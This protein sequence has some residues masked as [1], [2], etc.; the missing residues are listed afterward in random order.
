MSLSEQGD[1]WK[2]FIGLQLLI[3]D[4][5]RIRKQLTFDTDADGVTVQ[6][7]L[8]DVTADLSNYYGK[9][10]RQGQ[11]VT[12][13]NFSIGIGHES[14]SNQQGAMCAG[15]I[16]YFA[17]TKYRKAAWKYAFAQ[18]QKNRKTYGH[19]PV[20]G[21]DFRVGF[22]HN[23]TGWNVVANN[24]YGAIDDHPLALCSTGSSVG[25]SDIFGTWNHNRDLIRGNT[26][27]YAL[28]GW[29]ANLDLLDASTESD[30]D[31]IMNEA[32]YFT[33]GM[34]YPIVDV[35]NFSCA[36]VGVAG[37]DGYHSSHWQYDGNINAMCGL[38]GIDISD[39]QVDGDGNLD[40][41][42]LYIDFDVV[43]FTPI[44]QRR[45]P[46]RTRKGKKTKSTGKTASRRRSSG[47]KKRRR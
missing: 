36:F 28:A 10:I 17:P 24:A 12:M 1:L 4:M 35:V 47:K 11:V 43:K 32:T 20:K 25:E 26:E 46:N 16:S 37:S 15:R 30:P 13:T 6:R 44:K 23:V 2:T 34:A 9:L 22:L 27:P 8:I 21:Y 40:D 42:Y 45:K 41:F 7:S 39:T 29:Q 19:P 38:I 3:L 31:M 14:T 18:T 5:P 33:P